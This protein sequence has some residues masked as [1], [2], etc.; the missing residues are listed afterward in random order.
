MF[1]SYRQHQTTMLPSS[2]EEWILSSHAVRVANEV[3]NR[4]DLD[5]LL[6]SIRAAGPAVIIRACC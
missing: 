4:M 1:L 6:S 3:V 2:W 5:A